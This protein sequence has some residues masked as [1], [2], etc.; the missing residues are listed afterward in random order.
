MS[1][2]VGLIAHPARH[3]ISPRFQQPAF[4]ALGIDA[5]YEAWDVPPER[6]AAFIEGLRAAD[7]LGA[8]VTIPHKEAAARCM[9]RLDRT[10]RAVGAINTIVNRDGRLE[11]FNTDVVGFQRAL[12]AAGFDAASARAVIWGAGG[13]ARAVAWA[14]IEREA[15]A[16][17]VVNRTPERGRRLRDDLLRAGERAR[18]SACGADEPAAM[19]ALAACDLV[20][21]CTPV[22]MRG[23]AGEGLLPF[24]VASLGPTTMVVDLIASPPETPLVRAARGSGR[25]A[26]G[27]LPMLVYQGAASFAMWTGREP[28]IEAMF[29]AA[30]AATAAD[31]QP[32]RE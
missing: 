29:A 2:R 7:A 22:G 19:T 21:Q 26:L 18:V 10:A 9:D 17:T 27:G 32:Q 12:E 14:L 31:A 13:A 15:A 4:D 11:G 1:G 6:L 23:S 16:L 24:D 30:E 3:S 28:P 5:R 8:N 20:V 25:A